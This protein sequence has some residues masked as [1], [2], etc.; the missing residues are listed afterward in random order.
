MNKLK[1]EHYQKVNKFLLILLCVFSLL[2]ILQAY[3][4]SV[5]LGTVT[6][7][8]AAIGITAA[9]FLVCKINRRD[10]SAFGIPFIYFT[11]ILGFTI[12]AGGTSFAVIELT[13]ASLMSLLYVEPKI[14]KNLVITMDIILVAVEVALPINLIEDPHFAV[15]V[16][17]MVCMIFIQFI[18]YHVVKTMKAQQLE[19]KISEQKALETLSIVEE[20]ASVLGKSIATITE[21]ISETEKGA[22]EL[23]SEIDQINQ[24]AIEQV[25]QFVSMGSVGEE[26]QRKIECSVEIFQAIEEV[27]KGME[28]C[29]DLNQDNLKNVSKKIDEIRD[30]IRFTSKT[31]AEF[32]T[33]MQDVIKILGS[34]HDI[35]NQ[36]NLLALNASI[37]AARAGE[38]GKGF[39]VVAEEVRVLSEQT[40]STTTEIEVAV[41]SVQGKIKEV[42][43]TVE[44]GDGCAEEGQ[45]I[46]KD[47]TE[48]FSQMKTQYLDMQKIIQKQYDSVEEILNKQNIIKG[49]IE[50]SNQ[51][52]G[53]FL[54]ATEAV[55]ELQNSQQ[56]QVANI[57]KNIQTIEQQNIELE[58]TLHAQEENG[59]K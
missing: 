48:S 29:T 3:G 26:M 10:A 44:K 46:I 25:K 41:K 5:Y 39:A 31:V 43:E 49:N 22:L 32:S 35:S 23:T 6:V 13:M 18:G 24:E 4:V 38:A 17:H 27:Q 14:F 2:S 58:S 54:G 47:T 34:I 1:K 28:E 16:M 52:A 53:K 51:I 42:V 19:T 55:L 50:V 9:A 7:T 37:E 40:K 15:F 45:R 21:S 12:M 56:E 36:T 33:S 59:V 20:T 8:I 30:E 11:G 57:Q